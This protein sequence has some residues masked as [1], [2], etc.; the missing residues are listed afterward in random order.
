VEY[1][2]SKS[3][4]RDGCCVW[5]NG[6]AEHKPTNYCH[7]QLVDCCM[8]SDKKTKTYYWLNVWMV[9]PATLISGA[10]MALLY[11]LVPP[12]FALFT[13]ICVL[14]FSLEVWVWRKISSE[15][16]ANYARPGHFMNYNFVLPVK[17]EW[18]LF[19]A[20]FLGLVCWIK[21]AQFANG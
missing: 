8:P 10:T 19:W 11:L 4:A 20:G 14:K 5:N 9:V 21:Y 18:L 1:L 17:L 15:D 13:A 3:N 6:G 2:Y 16:R 12:F 7:I